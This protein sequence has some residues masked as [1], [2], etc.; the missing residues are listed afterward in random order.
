MKKL[1]F[2]SAIL[3]FCFVTSA[4]ADPPDWSVNPGD[5]SFSQ[6][7][8]G[9]LYL[10]EELAEGDEHIVAAFVAD[11]VR[12]VQ[13]A[14]LSP[15]GTW[16]YSMT[17]YANTEGQEIT[18][19]A[20]NADEDEIWL[21]TE[22]LLTETNGN[23]GDLLNPFEWHSYP[24]PPPIVEGIPDQTILF[25]DSF[26]MF[27]L[28][29]YLQIVDDDVVLWSFSGNG[30][31]QVVIDDDNQVTVTPPN[32]QW[33]GSEAIA[34][35]ATDSTFLQLA[36][37][38]TAVFTISDEDQPPEILDIPDQ[39]AERGYDF[40]PLNLDD[41]L[42]ESDGDSIRWAFSVVPVPQG[43]PA[44]NW[45]VLSEN[46]SYTM[47]IVA[48]ARFSGETMNGNAHIL[49]AFVDDECRGV[50]AAEFTPLNTW[51]YPLTVYGNTNGEKISFRYYNADLEMVWDVHQTLIFNNLGSLGTLFD[52]ITFDTGEIIFDIND[53]NQMTVEIVNA[54]WFGRYDV[55]LIAQDCGT[56]NQYSDSTQTNFKVDVRPQVAGILDQI[57][58]NMGPIYQS[59]SLDNYLTNI[60]GD[61]ILWSSN[62]S[63][64]LDITI[65][66]SNTATITV[67][68]TTWYGTENIV[69]TATDSALLALAD[70]DTAQFTRY[71]NYYPQFTSSPIQHAY[72]DSPYVY[73]I[74]TVDGNTGDSLVITATYPDW[75][76]FVD[77]GDGTALLSGTPNA[78]HI[79]VESIEIS[80]IDTLNAVT[81][82]NFDV[83][84]HPNFDVNAD[85][86]IDVMDMQIISSKIG[87]ENPSYD[88]DINGIVDK[89]DVSLIIQKINE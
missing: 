34:F 54:D 80:I 18:F 4:H 55:T 56:I 89:D 83:V 37:S 65:D 63:D 67:L 62:E 2:F 81:T 85:D 38:D 84:I 46:F 19:R 41:Y 7:V 79:S 13:I 53:E 51:V 29:D 24:D 77:Y 57:I 78:S 32:D 44:P 69:F 28:D 87:K 17:I 43:E 60:D 33:S 10:E 66:E 35:T 45:D 72:A 14:E 6:T 31:L 15:L 12:G 9:I 25:G 8:T 74:T 52:P 82:Q 36:D 68:D 86:K 21:V 27:D 75:L 58:A 26:E 47:P 30:E 40:T 70:S 64:F 5:Y 11:E 48:E 49:A 59:V 71:Y 88:L 3:I 22:T 76:S 1:V 73:A 23:Q 50:C 16:L 61:P 42:V 39:G 20:Y